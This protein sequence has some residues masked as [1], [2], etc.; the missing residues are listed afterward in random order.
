MENWFTTTT[1]GDMHF[2]YLYIQDEN[3]IKIKY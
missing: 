3:I 2:V 1:M